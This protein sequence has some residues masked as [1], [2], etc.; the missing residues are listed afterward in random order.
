MR[1]RRGAHDA[2][3]ENTDSNKLHEVASCR[4]RASHSTNQEN[5]DG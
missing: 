2:Y 5:L 3:A 4:G 1:V